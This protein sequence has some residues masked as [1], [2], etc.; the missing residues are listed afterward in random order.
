M[1]DNGA[2]SSPNHDG[3]LPNRAHKK[4]KNSSSSAAAAV[5]AASLSAAPPPV[6]DK[7]QFDGDKH[8][9]KSQLPSRTTEDEEAECAQVLSCLRGQPE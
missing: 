3:M 2:S 5:A 6:V 1:L 7:C 8:C 4:A 9:K